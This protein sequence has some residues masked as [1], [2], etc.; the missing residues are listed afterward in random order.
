MLSR[1]QELD[2]LYI[3]KELPENKI[4]ANQ[5]ALAE[6]DRLLQVSKNNNPTEWKS[7]KDK[8]SKIRISFLNSRSIKNKFENIKSDRC[9]LVSDIIFLSET[10]IEE[11]ANVTE[12]SI[13]EYIA[14]FNS[15]GRGKGIASYYKE[16][17]KHVMNIKCDGFSVSK[18]ESKNMDIICLYRSQGANDKDL[19]EKLKMIIDKGK[20]TIIGGDLN[21]CL[22]ANPENY[23][24]KSVT[25]HGFKHIVTESTHI[26]GGVI[27][28]I[29]TC[30][31]GV[32]LD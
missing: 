9:L 1:V 30:V 6:I 5:T 19:I 22:R 28:H 12:Y 10:W 8:D 7:K 26:D 24:T 31:R 4:Y 17:F 14:N 2:H 32:K 23:I 20:T 29:Y 18:L 21:V 25:E 27:D 15:K 11:N 16:N 13:K 3:L